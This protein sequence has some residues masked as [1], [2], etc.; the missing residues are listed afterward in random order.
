MGDS[1]KC[2]NGHRRSVQ[3]LM[4][5]ALPMLQN[6]RHTT[7][8][9]ILPENTFFDD[10][11]YFHALPGDRIKGLICQLVLAHDADAAFRRG[12]IVLKNNSQDPVTFPLE[13]AIALY[14]LALRLIDYQDAKEDLRVCLSGLEVG[15]SRK[16]VYVDG[17]IRALQAKYKSSRV[18]KDYE[19]ALSRHIIGLDLVRNDAGLADFPQE[20]SAHRLASLAA[21]LMEAKRPL[22]FHEPFERVSECALP[23]EAIEVLGEAGKLATTTDLK[24]YVA[25]KLSLA[26]YAKYISQKSPRSILD[27]AIKQGMNALQLARDNG[28]A[29]NSGLSAAF[30]IRWSDMFFDR[31][32]EGYDFEDYKS[33]LKYCQLA[34]DQTN[35]SECYLLRLCHIK[36]CMTNWMGRAFYGRAPLEYKADSVQ[37]KL[38]EEVI[39]DLNKA[40]ETSATAST[41]T[42]AGWKVMLGT[43]F[44]NLGGEAN[45]R[46]AIEHLTEA[47]ALEDC[48]CPRHQLTWNARFRLSEALAHLAFNTGRQEDYQVALNSW[49]ETANYRQVP[50]NC[51]IQRE[52]ADLTLQFYMSSPAKNHALGEKSLSEMLECLKCTIHRA[53]PHRIWL[54]GNAA[55][56]YV[57]LRKDSRNAAELITE[58]ITHLPRATQPQSSRLEQ[59][60]MIRRFFWIPHTALNIFILAGMPWGQAISLYES[61]RGILWERL[62]DE[63]EI[64]KLQIGVDGDLTEQL[65]RAQLVTMSRPDPNEIHIMGA[66]LVRLLRHENVDRYVDIL[67]SFRARPGVDEHFGLSPV[68]KSIQHYSCDGPIVIVN[69]S[70]ESTNAVVIS[71]RKIYSVAL[72]LL[73]KH[74]T[75]SLMESLKNFTSAQFLETDFDLADLGLQ[76]ILTS[77]WQRLAKPLLDS[78]DFTDYVTQEGEKPRIYWVSAGLL[79]LIPMHAVGDWCAALR[80]T[81]LTVERTTKENKTYTRWHEQYT[82]VDEELPIPDSVHARVVSS[83][84]PNLK[85]LRYIRG[86]DTA[87]RAAFKPQQ[88]SILLVGMPET[89]GARDLNALGEI[90]TIKESTESS[91]SPTMLEYPTKAEVID[92]LGHCDIAHF[93]CH[94]QADPHD[95]SLSCVMLQ[96][97]QQR[98]LNVRSLLQAKIPKCRLA[99][100]SACESM[101]VKDWQLHDEGIHVA[102]GFLMAGVP[103]VISTMWPVDDEVANAIALLFYEF[104]KDDNG[105]IDCS[106]S[107]VAL[108]NALDG[109]IFSGYPPILWAAYTHSGV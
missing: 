25:T 54:L 49:D 68:E 69:A 63:R 31:A 83:Y 13:N 20:F 60:H 78:I 17:M 71:K 107:A 74:E 82:G 41:R 90:Q 33:S 62:V 58:A 28:H 105:T 103:N 53:L 22:P 30:C 101:Q 46:L 40:L 48:S 34:Y 108:H 15:L 55:K 95:P 97:W 24:L 77:L 94:G 61:S 50:R 87:Q 29:C 52:I 73:E 32:L 3:E 7:A 14:A 12:C 18:H 26:L 89:P 10:L 67:Q 35:R 1:S 85:A 80:S 42:R 5:D 100:V 104:L 4:V 65:R 57:K 76:Y 44:V 43:A 38:L 2:H 102:G 9:R 91:M 96:D 51:A 93:A 45:V 36:V 106:T 39:K 47:V 21:W 64:P 70:F 92:A 23:N 86:R 8:I 72:P 66:E 11:E 88:R 75:N 56:L 81:R 59:L 79:S 19:V 84:I 16:H 98:P 37:Y 109:L 27:E 99:F 6:L